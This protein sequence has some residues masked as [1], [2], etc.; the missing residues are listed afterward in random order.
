MTELPPLVAFTGKAGCGKTTA[1]NWMLRNQRKAVRLSFARP[2]KRML[3][4][5]IREA[6]PRSWP[7]DA[8]AY[9]DDP[10]LKETPIPFLG[11]QTARRLLQTLGTEWGR[12]AVHPDFWVDIAAAK[13]E[14]AL[15]NETR[16]L[17][18]TTVK[19]VFDDCRFVNEA[20][21]VRRYGGVVVRIVRPDAA[22]SVEIDGHTSERME[23]DADVVV[24]NDG[25][26]FDLE[27][28]LAAM[29][30]PPS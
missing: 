29:F 19:V 4:E 2:L 16:G 11:N 6:V 22:K 13:V 7:H 12:N 3:Y 28:K 25:S 21:M 10:V 15:G 27:Q 20:A 24:V 1:A 14:R 30:P 26:V 23:F 5:L 17:D 18:K 9:I 8:K